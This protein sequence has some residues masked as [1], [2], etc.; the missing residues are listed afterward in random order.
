MGRPT[1][2]LAEKKIRSVLSVLAGEVAIAEAARKEEA[3]R[4]VDRAVEG[5][6]PRGRE[7]RAC[8]GQVRAFDA[9]GPTR[10]RDR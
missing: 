5:R 3:Q 4:A 1:S 9:R 8:R 6:V 10:G 2:I 7:D